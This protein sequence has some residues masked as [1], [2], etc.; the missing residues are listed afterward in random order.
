[1]RARAPMLALL[2]A[3]GGCVA[4]IGADEELTRVSE[5]ICTCETQLGFLGSR[6]DCEATIDDRLVGATEET[7][8]AWL[9]RFS[10][11]KCDKCPNVEAC[12]YTAP[13]CAANGCSEDKECCS[14]LDGGK[15][16]D[17]QCQ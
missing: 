14:Y 12:F 7:R 6:S 3:L 2:A 5:K 9:A 13:T 4:I 10:A 16:V 8:A 1:M 17:N 15:C 11:K